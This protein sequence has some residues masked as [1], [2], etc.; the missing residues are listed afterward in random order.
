MH[1]SEEGFM[2]YIPLVTFIVSLL[3]AVTVLD[4]YFA[5]RKPYQLLWAIGLLMYAV[6]T[7]TEFWWGVVGH[8]DIFYRLW[9]LIGAILVAAYLG[10]G[11]LYLLMKRRNAHIW[12]VLLGVFTLYAAVRVFMV[13]VDISGLT[14]LTGVGIMPKDL[15]LIVTPI[16]NAFGTIALVG[17]AVYSA[18]IFWRKRILPH[19]VVANVLIA[20]GAMLPAAGGIHIATPGGDLNLF[21]VMELAGVIIMFIGFLRTKEVFGVYRFPLAHGFKQIEK[22]GAGSP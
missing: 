10:Q 2:A 19:R 8:V 5:R 13:E 1:S 12:M 15:R 18:Y 4:Q 7:F 22:R 20:L 6:S 17:G 3:F 11:T 14:K 16:T 9:Y 21:F